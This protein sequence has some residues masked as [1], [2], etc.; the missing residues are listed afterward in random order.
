[1]R[2]SRR[3]VGATRLKAQCQAPVA[4]ARCQG[5][6]PGRVRARRPPR[7]AAPS[8]GLDRPSCVGPASFVRRPAP[9]YPRRAST[10]TVSRATTGIGS[11]PAPVHPVRAL[12][13]AFLL[14]GGVAERGV[15]VAHVRKAGTPDPSLAR[16][17]GVCFPRWRFGRRVRALRKETVPFSSNEN[18]DSPPP[19][20]SPV[21]TRIARTTHSRG[22]QSD[23]GP[24]TPGS[25]PLHYRVG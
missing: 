12:P 5:A 9:L 13:P 17:A 16:R 20:P 1:M 3:A 18:R 22:R 24:C 19:I 8:G 21:L 7:G 6:L 11:F 4:R 23:R 10:A 15:S 25:D 14:P 2:R